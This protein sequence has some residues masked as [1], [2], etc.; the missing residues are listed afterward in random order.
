MYKMA[1]FILEFST[2][3][4]ATFAITFLLLPCSRTN[5]L[6]V[7]VLCCAVFCQRHF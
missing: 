6:C 7:G 3:T 2:N 5:I 1:Q 4:K